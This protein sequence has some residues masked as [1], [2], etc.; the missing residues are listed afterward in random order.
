MCPDK[1]FIELSGKCYL[2]TYPTDKSYLRN[3]YGAVDSCIS[4]APEGAS[5]D[6]VNIKSKKQ[7]EEVE[8][9]I[10]LFNKPLETDE[11]WIRMKVQKKTFR[12]S[13]VTSTRWVDDKNRLLPYANF[14]D[15]QNP[16]GV[17]CAVLSKKHNYKWITRHCSYGYRDAAV[18]IT[19]TGECMVTA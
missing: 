9:A 11:I 12:N 8:K 3:V 2:M 14:A 17:E 10:A 6:L 16:V 13:T 1:S 5:A 4:L 19:N 7:Q 15:N 18:C